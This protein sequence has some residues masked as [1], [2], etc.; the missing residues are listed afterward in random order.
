MLP[1]NCSIAKPR[2]VELEKQL[3]LNPELRKGN[4]TIIKTNLNEDIVEEVRDDETFE[5]VYFLLHRAVIR[6]ERDTTKMRVVF[7]ASVK[8]PKQPSLNDIL[9]S[10]LCLLPLVQDIVLQFRIGKTAVVSDMQQAFLQISIA[11]THGEYGDG[12]PRLSWRKEQVEKLR[13]GNDN[14]VRGADGRVYQ[15]NFGKIIVIHK[16]LQLLAPLIK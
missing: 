10:G 9:N 4:D 11:E 5:N 13:Y 8:L 7:D 14:L 3:N 6:N 12:A 15:D 1:D 2:L 16:L